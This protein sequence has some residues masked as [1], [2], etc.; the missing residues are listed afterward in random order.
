MTL[1][2]Q[3]KS[4]LKARVRDWLADP[5][6]DGAVIDTAIALTEA[7]I[8]REL[9]VRAME[10]TQDFPI[11]G[12]T[13]TVPS[14]FLAIKRLYIPG[15]KPMINVDQDR[16][17]ELLALETSTPPEQP[18]YYAI[19]GREDGLPNIRFA[20]L[21]TATASYTAVISFFADPALI[22]DEDANDILYEHPDVYLYGTLTHLSGYLEDQN[23][24][25]RW[26]DLF[27]EAV[28]SLTR[29]DLDDRVAERDIRPRVIGR[30]A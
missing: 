7:K 8:R 12:P 24:V 25:P 2:F 18:T 17:I 3:N 4:E 19:E 13:Q 27:L 23:R 9:R 26:G 20:P 6:F 5:D 15:Y 30:L 21:Q 29:G 14:R 10:V 1:A 16:L 11:T 28:G 22:D